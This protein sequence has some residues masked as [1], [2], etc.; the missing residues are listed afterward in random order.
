MRSLAL[1]IA[2][3]MALLAIFAPGARAA[4]SHVTIDV[5]MTS[6]LEVTVNGSVVD[7]DSKGLPGGRIAAIVDGQTL[8]M[9]TSDEQGKFKLN[10]VVPQS[11]R[12]GTKTLSVRFL[13]TAANPPAQ[14]S[15]LLDMSE[16]AGAAAASPSPAPDPGTVSTLTAEPNNATPTNGSVVEISGQLLS[17]QGLPLVGAGISLFNGETELEETYVLTDDEGNYTTLFEV[18]VE[19]K[20]QIN[21]TVK[22]AGSGNY[23][24]AA[25]PVT[26]NVSF[27]EA[28][29]ESPTPTET[30]GQD[31]SEQPSSEQASETPSAAPTT[32][33]TPVVVDD[34]SITGFAAWVIGA[35]AIVGGIALI[36]VAVVVTGSLRERTKA[37]DSPDEELAQ[38]PLDLFDDDPDEP[39]IPRR[40]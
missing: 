23:P 29:A 24:A 7:N 12:G 13:G 18:P 36:V 10:F 37:A 2:I 35:L 4:G 34:S 16:V 17:P 5:S 15:V 22:F 30:E 33:D 21:L 19:Q 39:V 20:E 1:A 9:G 38:K 31:S 6:K 11:L 40:G 32:Q 26:L 3:A 8:T 27:Q 14:S 28:T 25:A